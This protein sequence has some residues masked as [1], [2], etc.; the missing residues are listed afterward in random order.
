MPHCKIC[1]TS[2]F[3]VY[4][5]KISTTLLYDTDKIGKIFKMLMRQ[6]SRK[7]RAKKE[8]WCSP[9]Q[10][11]RTKQDAYK[12]K[13]LSTICE[14]EKLNSLNSARSLIF[15]SHLLK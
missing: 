13:G 11:T 10:N 6:G 1:H 12:F 8:A 3:H 4:Y 9:L 7:Q 15:L 2:M 14:I 5:Y